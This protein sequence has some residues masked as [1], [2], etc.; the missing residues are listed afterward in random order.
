MLEVVP[1]T[2]CPKLEEAPKHPCPL[3][4]P[5][6]IPWESACWSASWLR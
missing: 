4:F 5:L 1:F 3:A 2:W 6:C